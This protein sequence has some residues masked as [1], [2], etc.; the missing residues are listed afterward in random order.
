M[1]LKAVETTCNINNTFV[2]GTTNEHIMRCCF[3]RFC[4]GDESP[5]DEE[6]SGRPLEVGSDQLRAIIEADHLKLR[7]SCQRTQCR[8]FYGCLAFDAN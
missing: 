5:E 1:G 7:K 2:P 6:C 8:Q 3:K 4:R